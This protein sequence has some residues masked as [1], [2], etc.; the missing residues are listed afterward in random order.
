[1]RRSAHPRLRRSARQAMVPTMPIV[2][3]SRSWPGRTITMSAAPTAHTPKSTAP[4]GI[5]VMLAART[6][7]RVAMTQRRHGEAVPFPD[8]PIDHPPRIHHQRSSHPP[9]EALRIEVAIS[10]VVDK[11]DKRVSL[12]GEILDRSVTEHHGVV[13]AHLRAS[14]TKG[15]DHADRGTLARIGDIRLIGPT[16][17]EDH[18]SIEL[19]DSVTDEIDDVRRHLIVHLAR[20]RDQSGQL[21]RRLDDKP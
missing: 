16:Q 20:S 18:R 12:I 4:T 14:T 5:A 1:M 15:I 11:K 9:R 2:A 13:L 3:N 17:R 7:A 8:R 10:G 19:A 21:G 6:S